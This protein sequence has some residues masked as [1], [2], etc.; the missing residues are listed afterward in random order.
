MKLANRQLWQCSSTARRAVVHR[1]QYRSI[2]SGINKFLDEKFPNEASSEFSQPA[3][4]V[5]PVLLTHGVLGSLLSYPVIAEALTREQGIVGSIAGDW[6]II[7]TSFPLSVGFM[8]SGMVSSVFGGTIANMGPRKALLGSTVCIG[9]G[10]AVSAVG[11]YMQMLPLLYFG[12]GTSVGAGVGLCYASPIQTLMHWFPE[13]KGI[14][15]GVA[16]SAIGLGAVLSREGLEGLL[17]RTATL[18]EYLGPLNDFEILGEGKSLTVEVQRAAEGA[19][20]TLSVVAGG[21]ADAAAAAVSLPTLQEGLYL[22]GEGSTGAAGALA[23]MSVLSFG[24]LAASAMLI[25][26]PPQEYIDDSLNLDD[27][28]STLFMSPLLSELTSRES[29][30]VSGSGNMKDV[31][32]SEEVNFFTAVR[33]T[34]K[35]ILCCNN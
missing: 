13:N 31:E 32:L 21:G 12:F 27:S 1:P 3:L 10:L 17:K 33:Y 2:F 35:N 22:V 24:A 15:G 8:L 14:C 30:S 29:K 28:K 9:S 20:E 25:R 6:D 4:M 5:A 18:P 23:A 7:E 11:V 19:S 34:A 16:A 26:T